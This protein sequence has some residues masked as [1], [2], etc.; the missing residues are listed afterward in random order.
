[1]LKSATKY[2]EFERQQIQSLIK[3][4]MV[5]LDRFDEKDFFDLILFIPENETNFRLRVEFES[6]QKTEREQSE[7]MEQL[8]LKAL[9]RTIDLRFSIETISDVC[10]LLILGLEKLLSFFFSTNKLRVENKQI[11]NT[12]DNMKTFSLIL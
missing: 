5:E 10:F 1:M 12:K 8:S 6:L 11:N 4:K 3:E 2:R 9:V 7:K